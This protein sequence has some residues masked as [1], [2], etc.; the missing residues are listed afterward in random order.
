MTTSW[1]ARK[2]IT[3]IFGTG[4]SLSLKEVKQRRYHI[5]DCETCARDGHGPNYEQCKNDVEIWKK[6]GVNCWR[7]VGVLLIWDERD[8]E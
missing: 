8:T 3:T 2:F 5:V 7:P 6:A 1:S 4:P